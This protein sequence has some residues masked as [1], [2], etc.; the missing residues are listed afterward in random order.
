MSVSCFAHTLQL[1]V[2]A[3][4]KSEDVERLISKA[5]SIVRHF[6]HSTYASKTLLDKQ[7]E[8]NLPQHKLI[9]TCKTRWNS[10]YAMLNVLFEQKKAIIAFFENKTWPCKGESELYEDD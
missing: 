9:Q 1:A 6:K 7:K 4:L 8:L 5:S 10:T 3:A 2:N